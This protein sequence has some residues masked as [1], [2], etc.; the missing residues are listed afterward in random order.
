MKPNYLK[1]LSNLFSKI[2]VRDA[3]GKSMDLNE[4]VVC[5]RDL[6]KKSS[7]DGNK[8]IA[9]GNGG[10]A[11]I[12]NHVTT[13][14]LKNAGI[15]AISFSDSALLTC[16]GNDLGYEQVYQ[17]PVKRL[18]RKGDILFSISSSGRS[19]NILN[20][21]AQAKDNGC[22]IITLSGFDEG[23]PLRKLGDINFYVPSNSYGY[24]EIVHQAIS[25]WI[26][27]LLED[28]G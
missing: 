26:I 11:A 8:T 2:E 28:H 16:L 1:E 6:I 4:A 20:A 22:F 17:T 12:A 18:A 10:S 5:A 13:D 21:A 23:N 27:D 19:K 25:H 24:V 7:G 9:I 3:S 14:L 15:P